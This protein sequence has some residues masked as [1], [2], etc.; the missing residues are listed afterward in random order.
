MKITYVDSNGRGPVIIDVNGVE[1][2]VNPGDTIEVPG[3]LAGRPPA[4]RLAELLDVE[5]PAATA[6][7][8][9]ERVRALKVELDGV[10]WGDGFL[11]QPDNW[12][13]AVKAKPAA[14]VTAVV[15]TS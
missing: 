10:D 4:A 12:Q 1:V 9:H 15:G 8:D 3:R 2:S 14:E 11:A 13:P 6:A 5:L 7:R